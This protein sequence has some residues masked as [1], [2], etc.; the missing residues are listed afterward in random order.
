MK[1][2]YKILWIDDNH[3]AVD[4]DVRRIKVFL[5]DHGIELIVEKVVVSA[6]HCPTTEQSFTETV[7]DFDL[8]MVFIDYRMP[9]QG[10]VIIKHIRKTLHH[11]HLPILF[12]TGENNPEKILPSIFTDSLQAEGNFLN[13]SDGIYFCDRDHI[14][15]KAELILTSLLSKE[16]APQRVR[17]LLM[18]KV[19]EIDASIIKAFELVKSKVPEEKKEKVKGSIVSKLQSRSTR[20]ATILAELSTK[21]F[22]ELLLVMSDR[23][24]LTFDS[25]SRAEILREMLSCIESLQPLGN[26]LSSF[27]NTIQGSPDSCLSKLRN[28]YAHKTAAEIVQNHTDTRCKY[29]RTETRRHLINA[30]HILGEQ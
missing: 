25:L 27:Y 16:K 4:G 15:E 1:T 5:E 13:I 12:Y 6:D 17:G 23:N 18:D 10:D 26:I 21:S 20:S 2:D 14:A 30:K 7:A 19:S 8:D 9:E 11:Y 29:I 3:R 22:D 28:E 24:N